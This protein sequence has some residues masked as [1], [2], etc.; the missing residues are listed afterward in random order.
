MQYAYNEARSLVLLWNLTTEQIQEIAGN[1]E[2]LKKYLRTYRLIGIGRRIDIV[3]GS[4]FIIEQGLPSQPSDNNLK[5]YGQAVGVLQEEA[6][7][8]HLKWWR[9]ITP[10]IQSRN[11]AK[12]EEI[13]KANVS[14]P[15]LA[16]AREWADSMHIE[17][18]EYI[19]SR[20]SWTWEECYQ[21]SIDSARQL[22]IA[23]PDEAFLKKQ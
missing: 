17:I 12:V 23:M 14:E 10:F 9:P 22:N 8:N 13:T 4:E 16:Q 5:A 20:T 2:E 7:G 1:N 21:R 11:W 19:D 3:P 15:E 6:G 18:D